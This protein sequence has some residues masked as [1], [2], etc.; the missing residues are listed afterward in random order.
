[1]NSTFL[2]SIIGSQ[3][4]SG[5][6]GPGGG[7]LG[8]CWFAAASVEGP[9]ATQH[10]LSGASNS[11]TGATFFVKDATVIRGAGFSVTR[12]AGLRADF[13][14]GVKING[15]YTELFNKLTGY[16]GLEHT[17]GLDIAVPANALV[18]FTYT[19]GNNFSLGVGM[20]VFFQ[21]T[22]STGGL[23]QNRVLARQV[24][25]SNDSN[26]LSP[27]E[28]NYGQWIVAPADCRITSIS[29]NPATAPSAQPIDV[30]LE[31]KTPSGETEEAFGSIAV[32]E[33]EVLVSGL[34]VAI[35]AGDGY[36]LRAVDVENRSISVI[37][38]IETFIPQAADGTNRWHF[39]TDV[40]EYTSAES[41]DY[42]G[43]VV[44]SDS[45]LV[46]TSVA[47]ESTTGTTDIQTL[48]NR[49]SASTIVSVVGDNEVDTAQSLALTSGDILQ[50][51]HT[52]GG[53]TGSGLHFCALFNTDFTAA[54]P[55]AAP[56]VATPHRYWR[57]LCTD[58][59]NASF[60]SFSE[61]QFRTRPRGPSVAEPANY[62]EGAHYSTRVGSRAFDGTYF[63][64]EWTVE[65]IGDESDAWIG[66]DLQ[67]PFDIVEVEASSRDGSNADHTPTAFD[68][69]WSDDGVTWTT[70]WSVD[71]YSWGA[72]ETR[73][74]TAPVNNY[75]GKTVVFPLMGQSN[76][77]G[78]DGP[79]DVVLDATDAQILMWDHAGGSTVLA[80]N[81]LDHFDETSDT[82]GPGLQFA[83]EF[84]AEFAPAK[85]ILVGL[86][87]GGTG[88]VAGDWNPKRGA[89]FIAAESQWEA[90]WAYIQ[91]NESD[92]VLGGALWVQGEDELADYDASFSDGLAYTA[93]P[94]G[95]FDIIRTDWSGWNAN[96]PVVFGGLPNGSA[97]NTK[98]NYASVQTAISDIPDNYPKAGYAYGE[99]LA[100]SDTI[101]WSAES[102]RTM[103]TRFSAAF[104]AAIASVVA[105]PTPAS[106]TP[107]G[108][109]V[110]TVYAFSGVGL[111]DG[112]SLR[113]QPGSSVS[114]W[115]NKFVYIKSGQINF[116][117][118]AELRFTEIAGSRIGLSDRDFSWKCVFASDNTGVEQ[119]LFSM[120]DTATSDRCFVARIRGDKL[121]F[122]GSSNGTAATLM[123]EMPLADLT[124]YDIEIRRVGTNIEL[125]SGGVSQDSY[126][127]TSGY[128]FYY[129]GA[130]GVHTLIGDH[131]NGRNF[132]GYMKSISL[133]FLS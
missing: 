79:V 81:P 58:A 61:L 20:T 12:V 31:V 105:H 26:V 99:D 106:F 66:N 126:T 102:A 55:A 71:T 54:G 60:Y 30:I 5:G 90:A 98:S 27:G 116:D 6:G 114:I 22:T 69:Q 72:S 104:E 93:M 89:T 59:D 56:V 37:G 63:T 21:D 35:T 74:F 112:A 16:T 39:L 130:S 52:G 2:A 33:T 28:K 88:F 92:V 110:E 45:E 119:G 111:P 50:F 51:A 43:F 131:I 117:G 124:E 84:L 68:V 101:H 8:T 86:A 40:A 122:Y 129:P 123:L 15:V 95:M 70:K 62:L 73:V 65:R 120:Y 77:I 133:E 76:M 25:S 53:G 107:D 97:I 17:T 44:N 132:D 47:F 96:T 113:S 80:A 9:N 94:M 109:N 32:G 18:E 85:V 100:V 75:E 67:T 1:M 128:T 115:E 57:I 11:F 19:S 38:T 29:L 34:D 49:G 14:C 125:F 78:R 103:G 3:F 42:A 10:F 87:D 36:R 118:D 64:N 127:L 48:V 91:A 23:F 7:P 46:H 82:V 83:K 4:L 24:S 41:L 13:S 108:S 121:E